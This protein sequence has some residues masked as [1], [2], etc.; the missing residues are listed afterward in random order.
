MK[1]IAC[2]LFFCVLWLAADHAQSAEITYNGKTFR[3]PFR[4]PAEEAFA[5]N[6]AA[7]SEQSISSMTLQGILYSLDKPLAIINGKIYRVGS[8]L[9]G[10]QVVQ[11]DKETVTVSV[12][13]RQFTLKQ[14][15]GTTNAYAQ[16]S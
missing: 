12:N 4:D 8:P 5:V 14:N 6:D 7:A 10:G 2:G 16:K 3:D 15:K 1:R 9:G 11:I 13:G